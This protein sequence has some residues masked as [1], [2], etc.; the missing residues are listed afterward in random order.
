MRLPRLDGFSVLTSTRRD[1]SDVA[2]DLV[3]WTDGRAGAGRG[4][5][6][7]GVMVPRPK[8]KAKGVCSEG[9]PKAVGGEAGLLHL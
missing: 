3:S 6:G 7:G 9:S 4:G 8:E 5:E 2:G 1:G